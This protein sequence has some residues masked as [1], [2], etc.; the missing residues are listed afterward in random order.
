MMY[1]SD[2]LYFI[3]SMAIL[4]IVATPIGNLNDMT[5]RGIEI[6]K[7]VDIIACEDTRRTKKLL[8]H[9]S[10]RNST[11]SYGHNDRKAKKI[12]FLLSQGKNIALVTD[13]GTPGISDPGSA[14]VNLARSNGH[15]VIPIPGVSAVTTLLSISGEN[16]RGTKFQ[17]FLSPKKSRRFKQLQLLLA[18]GVPFVIFEGPHRV[19]K[20][21]AEIDTIENQRQL[22]MARELTKKYEE[23]LSGT[24]LSVLTELET[25]DRMRGEFVLLVLKTSA[26]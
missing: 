9:F 3:F 1:R 22:I 20:L 12:I 26:S 23:I 19:K 16:N 5:F 8:N 18:E 24:A 21:L 15:Y 11:I 4:Y 7:E 14:A 2:H 13:A 17:G 6:L 10:I 25:K